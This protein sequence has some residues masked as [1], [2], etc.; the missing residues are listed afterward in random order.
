[1]WAE[2]ILMAV[3]Q[4]LTEFL[5]VSS[6]GHGVIIPAIVG[7]TDPMLTGLNFAVALH[8]GTG[9]ALLIALWSDWMWLVRGSCGAGPDVVVARRL[10]TAIIGSTLAIGVIAIPLR[11]WV[12][13]FRDPITAAWLLIVFGFLLAIADRFGGMQHG[14]RSTTLPVWLLIGISQIVA[15]VPGV[16][17]AGIT[18][19]VARS[20]GVIRPTAARFSFLLMAPAVA[21]AGVV[22]IFDVI[23]GNEPL[24]DVGLLLAGTLIATVVGVLV[25]R[26]LLAFLHRYSLAVFAA[27]RVVAGVVALSILLATRA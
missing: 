8:L 21:G 18:M 19:T 5:P 4:A 1:M 20:F 16:S 9:L 12:S 6:S 14:L 3:I 10:S 25:V 27:Y 15:L 2:V 17:R 7:W 24:G 23:Q 11:D 22:Q 13:Q 26:G